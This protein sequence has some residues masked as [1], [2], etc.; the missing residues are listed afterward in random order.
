[1]SIKSQK[2]FSLIEIALGLLILSFVLAGFNGVFEL[3]FDTDHKMEEQQNMERIDDS[4]QTYLSVN[5][6]LPCPDTDGDG[7][8]NRTVT[9]GIS[10]C[11]DREGTLPFNDL[12]V[13]EK[14]AWGN[15]YYY[16]VHQRAESSTYVNDICEPASVLGKSGTRTKANLW[17]CPATNIYYCSASIT[18]GSDCNVSLGICS[19]PCTNTT[20]PR[21][22]LNSTKPPFF[23]LATPPY[24]GVTGSYNLTVSDEDGNQMG[25]GVVAVVVSWGANG[26]KVNRSSCSGG[27]ADELENCDDDRNFVDTQ[28][29]KD[30]DFLT[31]VTVNQAKVAI[32][33]T[34]EFR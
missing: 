27:T 10:V 9:S 34:G 33:G 4:I 1:M 28:T 29:G 26:N 6:Y 8:E 30:R 17:L 24:G 25:E 32:I 31:W 5:A 15:P 20:D 3:V 7:V 12:G 2:G 23:H 22:L 16:R 19:E 13:P 14:D 11:D 21:P 18:A